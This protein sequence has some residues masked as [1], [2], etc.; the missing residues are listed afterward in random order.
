MSGEATKGKYILYA[1]D[2]S[3]DQEII[4]ESLHGI[5][6]DVDLV[7]VNNGLEALHFLESLKP[8]INYPCLILLDIN[9][10][11]LNGIETLKILK[12]DIV[13]KK[14]PVIMFST[15]SDKELVRKSLEIGAAD[16]ITKP[17]NFHSIKEVTELIVAKCDQVKE[18][19]V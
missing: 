6:C 4:R 10:P 3:E 13:L 1:D 11:I 19:K 5:H 15:S 14:I 7:F 9:M 12:Q 18:V 8:G 2:D 16:Y 17:I